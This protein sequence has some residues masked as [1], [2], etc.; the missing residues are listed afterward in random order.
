[1]KKSKINPYDYPEKYRLPII[2]T[3][4]DIEMERIYLNFYND[5]Y[6]K[7]YDKKKDDEYKHKTKTIQRTSIR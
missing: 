2:I 3:Q 5:Q 6:W 4:R 1:M 7:E